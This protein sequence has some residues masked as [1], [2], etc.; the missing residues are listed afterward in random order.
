MYVSRNIDPFRT[1]RFTGLKVWQ[2]STYLETWLVS[3]VNTKTVII[4]V[5]EDII[6]SR[7]LKSIVY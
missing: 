3:R 1:S 2:T 7:N 5:H 4:I 6:N